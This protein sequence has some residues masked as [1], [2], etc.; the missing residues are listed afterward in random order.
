[1]ESIAKAEQMEPRLNCQK[2]LP[3][4]SVPSLL[5]DVK[6]GLL[7][8]PRRLPA[9]YFYDEHGSQLF[10]KICDTHEYYPTRTEDSLLEN[11]AEDIIKHCQPAHLV[12]LGSGTS[13]K[14]RRLF[15]ACEK[16]DHQVK[17]WPFDVCEEMVKKASESLV[18]EYHWLDV[19]GLVGDYNAGLKHLPELPGRS[20]YVF[21]G[22][23]IG[24]FAHDEGVA[25]LSE[26]RQSMS[27]DDM[28]LMG[29]DRIKDEGILNSAYNDKEGITAAFNLNLLNVLNKE[30]EADFDSEKFKHHAFFNQDE[31]QIEM[32]LIATEQQT[33]KLQALETEILFEEGD[34]ILTE[35][36]R[37]FTQTSLSNMLKEAG[38]ALTKHFSP[39][40][41]YFSLVLASPEA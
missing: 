37:K 19:N 38:F 27:A 4:R 24:N 25:F 14:T 5:D 32:H 6:Q 12:E 16:H 29:A 33:V 17:Y 21:L 36:S 9:K 3:T 23:T 26:L 13:R 35:I 11:A 18:D 2:V 20:L 39:E 34:S 40:N 8:V 1:M 41:N 15:D 7:Q 30:V 31:S 10:D 22:G 28:L